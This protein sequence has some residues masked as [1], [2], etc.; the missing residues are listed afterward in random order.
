MDPHIDVP[1]IT[2]ECWEKLGVSENSMMCANSRMVV[3]PKETGKTVIMPCTLLAY[4]KEFQLGNKLSLAR[5]PISLNHPNCS[6]FCVLG[7]GS[8]NSV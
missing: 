2:S 8:C 3:K 5:E 7:G 6:R 4:Q 1:E